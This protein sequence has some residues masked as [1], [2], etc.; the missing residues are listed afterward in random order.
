MS[1]TNTTEVR[2]YGADGL[3][4]QRL[5]MHNVGSFVLMA[6]IAI[7]AALNLQKV[8]VDFA[9]TSITMSLVFVIVFTAILGFGTGYLYARNRCTR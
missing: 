2:R 7:F 3:G 1:R 6:A 4:R 9:F 5:N 8:N